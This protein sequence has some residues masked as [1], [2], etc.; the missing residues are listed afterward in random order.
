ADRRNYVHLLRELRNRF[1]ELE[2][3]KSKSSGY[4][5][6]FAGAAGHWVLK[7]GYDL[8]QLVKYADFVNV[9]SYDYFGAWQSK[10][11]AF[12]GPPAPLFFAT[13]P[14]FSGRMNVH[15]TLKYY[16]CQIKAT[17]K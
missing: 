11:G 5:I 6:S 13:P 9:M 8:V 10:W 4:L 14:K 3:Q 12:T 7:P 15:A 1:R 2:E 16:S 17:N